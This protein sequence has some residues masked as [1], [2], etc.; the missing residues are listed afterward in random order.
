MPGQD[1]QVGN[2]AALA[3]S[4]AELARAA[5]LA[6]RFEAVG[7]SAGQAR[8]AAGDSLSIERAR[9]AARLLALSEARIGP[10]LVARG[11]GNAEPLADEATADGAA[12]NRSASFTAT[13]R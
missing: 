6:P 8:D 13:F 9:T 10:Y 4:I 5:S 3:L 2:L 12:Q 7:H 11:A 1:R